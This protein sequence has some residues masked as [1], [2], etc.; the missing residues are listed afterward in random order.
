MLYLTLHFAGGHIWVFERLYVVKVQ[1]NL[2]L[3]AW[4]GVNACSV[5]SACVTAF[6]NAVLFDRA[7]LEGWSDPIVEEGPV[8]KTGG[9]STRPSFRLSDA[10]HNF[11]TV[12]S[13]NVGR[14][15]SCG[16]RWAHVEVVAVRWWRRCDYWE[17]AIA[18][19]V[20]DSSWRFGDFANTPFDS[21][22]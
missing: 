19:E 21:L 13:L 18:A 3:T 4:R 17:F 12:W 9:T 16:C 15:P 7:M 5:S 2:P 10:A 20:G 1:L 14:G 6:E 11:G 22:F 8:K